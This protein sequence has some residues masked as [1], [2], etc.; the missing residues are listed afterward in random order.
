MERSWYYVF[1]CA[2]N[3]NNETENNETENNETENNE[4]KL[5]N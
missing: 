5:K 3:Q 1:R 2:A 4:N